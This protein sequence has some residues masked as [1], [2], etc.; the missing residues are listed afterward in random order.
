MENNIRVTFQKHD[1]TISKTENISLDIKLSDFRKVVQLLL[2]FPSESPFVLVLDRNKQELDNYGT[3]KDAGIQD[4]DKIIL[5]PLPIWNKEKH[6]FVPLRPEPKPNLYINNGLGTWQ[7]AVIIGGVIGSFLV[8]GLLVLGIVNK[9]QTIT[10]NTTPSSVNSPTQ[11]AN[12][13]ISSSPMYTVKA[14]IS[15]LKPIE[16][17]TTASISQ[18]AAIQ[19]LQTWLAA[20]RQIFSPPYNKELGAK[21]LT[22][23]VYTKFITKTDNPDACL[24]RTNNE[25]DCLSSVDWLIRNRAY[26]VYGV[27]KIQAVRNFVSSGNNATIAVVVIEQRTLYNSSGSVDKTQSGLFTSTTSYDLEY[28]NGGIKISNYR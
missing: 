19:A 9:P 23:S 26:W 15:P 27:Q 22:G 13:V 21:L 5:Y 7:Q 14:E 8:A 16:I 11:S 3:L 6:N 1:A 28:Q 24:A 18:E 17:Q 4:N 20:K 12:Q 25:D 2:S 10:I